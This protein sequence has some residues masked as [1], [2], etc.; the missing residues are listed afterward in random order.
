MTTGTR[1]EAL[2]V[3]RGSTVAA[4]IL[5][6]TPGNWDAVYWPLEHAAWHGWTPTDLVFPFFLFAMGAAVPI[7]LARRRAQPRRVRHH[8]GR[9][10]LILFGLG[11]LLNAMNAPSPLVWSTFRIPG[12][13]QR[14]AIVFVIIAWLTEKRSRSVQIG[15][16][17]G[18]LLVYWAA[19]M[20][21]PVPGFGPGVLTPNGNLA[22]FLDRLVLR[23]HLA[24]GTW[25]P[26][27]ILSTVPAI[28]TALCGV[29]AGDWLIDPAAR[30]HR[31]LSLWAAGAIATVA[32]LMWDLVFPI[33]KNLW[34]SSFALLAAGV[35]TQLLAVCYW[36]LDVQGVKGW[37]LPFVAFGRN[38]LA[39]YFLSVS[40]DTIMTR[41]AVAAPEGSLKWSLYTHAFESPL[42]PCCG[43]ELASMAYA[44]AYV[45]LW[46]VVVIIM[47][48][49]RIFVGI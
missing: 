29:F 49:R 28:A 32:A 15:V 36:V 11:L 18:V 14:I 2:D 26:E 16:V 42:A 38:A 1:L 39:A 6:S 35:A 44:I 24:F 43:M 17:A 31:A 8:V 34:T 23:R 22:S 4:M 9:R 37:S 25:D 5:V 19:M 47:Y 13:L 20:L 45:A 30:P 27:G 48:R 21:V 7:A 41:W 12:V 40:L 10:A 46:A 33:N 3:F